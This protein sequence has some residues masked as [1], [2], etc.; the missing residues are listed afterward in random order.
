M[1]YPVPRHGCQRKPTVDITIVSRS[2]ESKNNF[3]SN[4][5]LMYTVYIH[6]SP[7]VLV[8]MHL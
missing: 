3:K 7:T 5:K 2:Q 1:V 8:L 6:Q 4:L